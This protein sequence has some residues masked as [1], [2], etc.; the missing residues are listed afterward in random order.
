MIIA[1]GDPNELYVTSIFSEPTC[2]DRFPKSIEPESKCTCKGGFLR[3]NGK[4]ISPEDCREYL[5]QN[6][7]RFPKKCDQI[8]KVLYFL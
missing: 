2:G 1:C 4:C 5:Q 3:E 6:N 8:D 7:K